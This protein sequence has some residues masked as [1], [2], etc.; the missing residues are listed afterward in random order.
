[1]N[2]KSLLGALGL[3][4]FNASAMA[5]SPLPVP[6]VDYSADRVLD[7]EKGSFSQK[8]YVSG[9]KERSEMDMGGMQSVT[10]LR[11]DKQL[12]WRLMP[13]QKM[14]QQMDLAKAREQTGASP[15]DNVEITVEGPDTIEGH[16]TTKYK[17]VTAD[18][19]YGGFMWFTSDGIA[20]K[21]DLLSREGATKSRIQM[22]LKNLSV[23][24]QD[25][26]LFEL[27]AGYTKMPSFGGLSMPKFGR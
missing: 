14:Y 23:G 5:Q 21:M 16:A 4:L 2:V 20:I 27:P 25:E 19:K 11:P 9:G 17:L 22:T 3:A 12:G 7:T 8:V 6:T 1:M 10:I 26:A 13:M 24:A 18:K 15:G